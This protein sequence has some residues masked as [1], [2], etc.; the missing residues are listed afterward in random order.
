MLFRGRKGSD[1]FTL[2]GGT[3]VGGSEKEGVL[4]AA[5]AESTTCSWR[6]RSW[7]LGQDPGGIPV[8]CGLCGDGRN[9]GYA[10]VRGYD[11]VC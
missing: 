9:A 8:S 11:V 2:N 4:V 6:I 1:V 7:H 3:E 5:G 10:G